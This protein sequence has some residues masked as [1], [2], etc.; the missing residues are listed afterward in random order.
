MGNTKSVRVTFYVPIGFHEKILNLTGEGT[1]YDNVAD[2]FV[3]SLRWFVDGAMV[4]I[5]CRYDPE[6]PHDTDLSF[7]FDNAVQA[8]DV[9]SK[10]KKSSSRIQASVPEGLYNRAEFIHAF[11]EFC[12]EANKDNP[13]VNP[14]HLPPRTSLSNVF[15]IA[16]VSYVGH[17]EYSLYNSPLYAKWVKEGHL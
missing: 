11:V 2:L 3:S 9:L 12:M 16:L 1:P 15:T 17:V 8:S 7:I 6:Q 4:E 5:A 10:Y 14:E 13:A